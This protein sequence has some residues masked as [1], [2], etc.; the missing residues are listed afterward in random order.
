MYS[1][2]N[3]SSTDMRENRVIENFKSL[4]CDGTRIDMHKYLEASNGEEETVMQEFL[5]T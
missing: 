4:A 3:S 5:L 2:S 1:S